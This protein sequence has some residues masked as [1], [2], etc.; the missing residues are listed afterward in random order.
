MASAIARYLAK[1]GF[2]A[3]FTT[4]ESR[5]R[6]QTGRGPVDLLLVD[7]PEGGHEPPWD[8]V[9]VART[10]PSPVVVLLHPARPPAG[11][12]VTRDVQPAAVIQK[13]VSW[14]QVVRV[15]AAVLE[16]PLVAGSQGS[17]APHPPA[18]A[19]PAP[20]PAFLAEMRP[21]SP[22]ELEALRILV[23]GETNGAI[24][25]RMALSEPTVKKHVQQI[26]AKLRA[27]DRTHAAVIALRT[28][29][30]P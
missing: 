4:R 10:I 11:T 15:M 26:I 25:Q 27:R 12:P 30:A 8:W 24:A 28:G 3:S 13:P 22:R 1:R 23:N 5:A 7:L 20:T 2:A 29:L 14:E 16:R 19:Y 6:S 9:S 21:L 18:G 17:G